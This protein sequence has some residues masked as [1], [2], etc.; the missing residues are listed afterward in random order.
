M[1][2]QGGG[3]EWILILGGV[4]ELVEGKTQVEYMS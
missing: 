3:S 1:F 4:V 2:K